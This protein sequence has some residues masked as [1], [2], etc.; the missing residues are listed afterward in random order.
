MKKAFCFCDG[1]TV[2][3]PN[4]ALS[5]CVQ[6]PGVRALWVKDPTDTVV[7]RTKFGSFAGALPLVN[8]LKSAFRSFHFGL[9]ACFGPQSPQKKSVLV[10]LL[11]VLVLPGFGL[12]EVHA[13]GRQA[14]RVFRYPGTTHSTRAPSLCAHVPEHCQK[15]GA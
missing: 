13:I 1:V 12:L 2:L 11:D 8:G 5:I 10:L 15:H 6:L 4:V 7:A 9:G 3:S 14:R